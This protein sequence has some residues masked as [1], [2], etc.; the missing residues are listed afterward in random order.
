M[1]EL[2]SSGI[3]SRTMTS[4]IHFVAYKNTIFLPKLKLRS[5]RLLLMGLVFSIS[6]NSFAETATE[7]LKD[8]EIVSSSS[9]SKAAYFKIKN[10][11]Y[12]PQIIIISAKSE[13]DNDLIG[14]AR[15]TVGALTLMEFKISANTGK[16]FNGKWAYKYTYGPGEIEKKIIAY[17]YKFPFKENTTVT[18]CQSKDGVISSHIDY[19]EAIDFC[20]PLKTPILAARDGIVISV[21]QNNTECGMDLSCSDKSNLIKIFHIDGSIALY[22]HIFKN[23]AKVKVGQEVKSGD[24]IAEVGA[25]GRVSGPHLHFDLSKFDANLVKTYIE[26]KF[27]KDNNEEIKIKYATKIANETKSSFLN[28]SVSKEYFYQNSYYGKATLVQNKNDNPITWSES[29]EKKS[30]SRTYEEIGGDE[31]YF[32]LKLKDKDLQIL[33]PKMGGL[34]FISTDNGLN[35]FPQSKAKISQKSTENSVLLSDFIESFSSR[36]G[37]FRKYLINNKNYWVESNFAPSS[38]YF[39]YEEIKS[40][41]KGTH[42][43]DEK[44][45]RYRVISKK[46]GII[47]FS[48]DNGK[49]LH[50]YENVIENNEKL[51][52][53]SLDEKLANK[54]CDDISG[55]A[56][57]KAN[58]CY[59]EKDYS[60]VKGL[61]LEYIS[62]NKNNGRAYALLAASYT[63]LEMHPEAIK[64]FELAISKNWISYDTCALYARSLA[65]LGL[66][67]ESIKWNKKALELVPS[68]VDITKILAEQLENTGRIP[69]AIEI[70]VNFDKKRLRDGKDELFEDQISTLR[71]KSR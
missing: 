55:D 46:N 44:N 2:R 52:S 24:Q 25:T 1:L 43:Y 59:L 56:L 29:Y 69:E 40:D 17:N 26:P 70:L 48:K 15:L 53:T 33:L 64:M 7:P 41:S 13:V 65:S 19:P 57:V 62:I 49:T 3:R 36:K 20:A 42:I 39:I 31:R 27:F 63:N 38:T 71:N 50:L 5:F 66:I 30:T 37:S 51:D 47:N 4:K 6:Q 35:F 10:N 23:S 11:S 67:N 22:N 45:D 68:L 21:I 28:Q 8:I 9:N 18:I 12:A 58:S 16:I 61:L 14:E 60:K 34:L 32:L 54:P